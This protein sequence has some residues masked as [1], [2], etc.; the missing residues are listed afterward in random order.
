M[1]VRAMAI[2]R[3]KRIRI[4]GLEEQPLPAS[5]RPLPGCSSREF[6]EF[7]LDLVRENEILREQ[8][9]QLLEQN[10]QYVTC[11][12]IQNAH[13]KEWTYLCKTVCP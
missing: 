7:N 3:S 8:N 9:R 5:S 10:K 4:E 13:F 1:D 12:K 11:K 6:H 2:N